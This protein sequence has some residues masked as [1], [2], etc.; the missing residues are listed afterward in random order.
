MAGLEAVASPVPRA[1]NSAALILCCGDDV[2]WFRICWQT[3]RLS[4][5]P[6]TPDP[7]QIFKYFEKTPILLSQGFDL[8]LLLEEI[9]TLIL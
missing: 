8:G 9:V 1:Y 3:L 7:R 5:Q 6:N 4:G 2:N